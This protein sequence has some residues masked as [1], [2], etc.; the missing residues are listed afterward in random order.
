MGC[1]LSELGEAV[2]GPDP[3][4]INDRWANIMSIIGEEAQASEK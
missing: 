2:K 3:G 4:P 1:I